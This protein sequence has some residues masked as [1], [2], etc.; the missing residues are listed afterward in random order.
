MTNE[1]DVIYKCTE[2]YV[3]QDERTLLWNDPALGIDWPIANPIISAKDALGV[4]LA[5]AECFR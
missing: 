4:H 5:D 3:P 1:A 2:V